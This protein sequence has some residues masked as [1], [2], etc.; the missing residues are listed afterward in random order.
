MKK[1]KFITPLSRQ[2][3]HSQ[4]KLA[5]ALTSVVPALAF[6]YLGATLHG[7]P[8][9][10]PFPAILTVLMSTIVTAISGYL[11]LRK[12]PKNIIKL[13]KY[14]TDVAEG[15]LPERIDLE[16]I[17][18]SDDLK[19]IEFGFN[20]IL[21]EMAGRLRIIEEKYKI[22]SGLRKALEERQ[23]ALLRAERHRVMIQSLGAACHH[24]GQPATTLR[25][26]LFILKERAQT[27][28]EMREIQMSINE[29]DAIS[30]V[31]RRLQEVNEF[32]TESYLRD[33]DAQDREILAI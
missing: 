9:D 27:L 6:Y 25:M 5:F 26:R 24:L 16:G 14:I 22:E 12:Y 13:R 2:D 3:A 20:T 10:I 23:Q 17:G 21:C 30:A 32:R 18:N 11:I 8:E 33:G 4:A 31:L 7:K 28:D 1:F 19:Y 15:A 29:V